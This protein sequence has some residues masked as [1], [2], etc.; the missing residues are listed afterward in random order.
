MRN[1]CDE[2]EPQRSNAE[3]HMQRIVY[4]VITGART[5]SRDSVLL[6]RPC[7]KLLAGSTP[8]HSD[9]VF[10]ARDFH[11]RV[12]CVLSCCKKKKRNVSSVLTTQRKR[13]W[14]FHLPRVCASV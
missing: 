3:L 5:M 7:V 11:T 9:C 1:L 6:C 4:R 10:N 14:N 12:T 13:T 2:A 8:R